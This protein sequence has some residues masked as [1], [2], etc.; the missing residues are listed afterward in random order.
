LAKPV[1][2]NFEDDMTV[3]LDPPLVRFFT[4]LAADYAFG[5]EAVAPMVAAAEALSR[6]ADENYDALQLLQA[7][8]LVAAQ[9]RPARDRFVDIAEIVE[10]R[11]RVTV[12]IR[13]P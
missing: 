2:E 5:E 12:V 1:L 9:R 8:G 4:E 13:K 6:E 7:I 10:A 3:H 11:G